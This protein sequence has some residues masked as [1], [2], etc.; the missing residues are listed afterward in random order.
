MF[1]SPRHNI[2]NVIITARLQR[3]VNG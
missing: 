2:W 3:R 1:V